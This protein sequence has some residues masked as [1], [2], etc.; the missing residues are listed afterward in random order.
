[1]M[2]SII[3]LGVWG[4]RTAV[5][6]GAHCCGGNEGISWLYKIIQLTG[7]TVTAD[8]LIEPECS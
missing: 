4:A 6:I 8:R 7:G 5:V 2:M 3:I 1:M